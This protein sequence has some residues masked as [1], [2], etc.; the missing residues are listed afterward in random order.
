MIPKTRRIH[1]LIVVGGHICEYL[2]LFFVGHKTY[3][4]CSF[5]WRN[6]LEAMH[7]AEVLNRDTWGKW[8]YGIWE[9]TTLVFFFL[10]WMSRGWMGVTSPGGGGAE[11]LCDEDMWWSPVPFTWRCFKTSKP[12]QLSKRDDPQIAHSVSETMPYHAIS[13]P[14][15]AQ[16]RLPQDSCGWAG[17]H[18]LRCVFPTNFREKKDQ[19]KKLKLSQW[20]VFGAFS[21]WST[22]EWINNSCVL[23]KGI[24]LD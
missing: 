10:F 14:S 2:S 1:T 11:L 17:L 13:N 15:L 24:R 21:K 12:Q 9:D 7:H 19:M 5:D 3:R 20:D 8:L 23:R 18:A 22:A 6:L 4:H 16:E